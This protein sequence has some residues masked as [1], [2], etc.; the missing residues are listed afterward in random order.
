MIFYLFSSSNVLKLI[1][2]T[3][4]VNTSYFVQVDIDIYVVIFISKT[5][6]SNNS[7]L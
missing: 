5:A 2:G 4:A 6:Q 3:G 1:S 7:S